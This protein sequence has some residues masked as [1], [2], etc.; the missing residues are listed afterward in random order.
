MR[1]SITKAR[2]PAATVD[3][4]MVAGRQSHER[5]YIRQVQ[6]VSEW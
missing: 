2:I 4:Q 5:V 6:E 1:R 3:P